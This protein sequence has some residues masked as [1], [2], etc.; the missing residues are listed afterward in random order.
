MSKE[1]ESIASAL[2]DK[3][4]S[5]FPGVVIRD[6]SGEKIDN[7]ENAKRFTFIYSDP[8]GTKFGAVSLSLADEESL[9]VTFPT[10][11]KKNMSRDQRREWSQFLRNLRKFA[12]SNI[13]DYD[14]KDI[15]KSALT[16]K[17]IKQNA[18][19]DDVATTAD[20]PVTESKLYGTMMQSRFDIGETRL[21]IHHLSMVRD[22]VHGDRSRKIDKIFIETA[23]GERF[24]LDFTNLGGAKAMCRHINEGGSIHDDIGQAISRMV[25]EMSSMRHFVRSTKNRQFEDQETATMTQHAVNHY[26]KLK[27]TL[28]HLANTKHYQH[29]VDSYKPEQEQ[30]D[31][32][33]V[34]ALRERFVKKFYDER[35]DEAL[36]IVYREHQR[37]KQ[38]AQEQYINELDEWANS[39]LEN[40]EEDR[41]EALKRLMS[42]SVKAGKD[43][44]EA[45]THMENMFPDEDI[46]DL[47]DLLGQY[48]TDNGPDADCRPV[49]KTWLNGAHPEMLDELT[50]GDKNI[51]DAA[52]NY[53]LPV[54]PKQAHPNDTYGASSLDDPV[55]DPNIPTTMQEDSLD[56]IRTLAGLKR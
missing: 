55:T 47:L 48:G 43:G 25:S 56:F 32:V 14:V 1:I 38:T 20:V 15:A 26:M 7:P 50:L 3:I 37:S 19:T 42:S 30:I 12:M 6:E 51:D 28:R 29:F 24:L 49:I 23:Q 27:N 5:R 31:E 45:Q 22:D 39:L 40:E 46:S 52:T 54:S 34:A 10:D 53:I 33:D 2:F 44:V 41:E 18:K 8:D 9:K 11:I 17:D 36:P 21:R 16:I 4:R 13:L 35:F